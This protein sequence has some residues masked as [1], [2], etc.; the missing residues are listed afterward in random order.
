MVDPGKLALN[1]EHN[2]KLIDP[3]SGV[4]CTKKNNEGPSSGIARVRC[5]L[6]PDPLPRQMRAECGVPEP[7]RR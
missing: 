7:P 4:G 5:D 1:D 6:I 2:Q 3:F